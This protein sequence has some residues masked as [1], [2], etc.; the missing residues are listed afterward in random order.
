MIFWWLKRSTGCKN[1]TLLLSHPLEAL[2][3][4]RVSKSQTQVW[5]LAANWS[6]GI[7]EC[8]KEEQ[9]WNHDS[10]RQFTKGLNEA[11]FLVQHLNW[12]T[13]EDSLNV[14]YQSRYLLKSYMLFSQSREKFSISSELPKLP[15]LLSCALFALCYI[16]HV[17]MCRDKRT[18]H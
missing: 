2:S 18:L 15:P 8:E 16:V 17:F 3:P 10:T 4:K 12:A 5:S 14:I 13:T 9:Q 6:C 11:S 1:W 7:N